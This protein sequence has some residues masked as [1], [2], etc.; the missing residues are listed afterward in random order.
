VLVDPQLARAERAR[1]LALDYT[2]TVP[3]QIERALA[4]HASSAHL[5]ALEAQLASLRVQVRE[6]EGDVH[7]LEAHVPATMEQPA[8][9]WLRKR[10]SSVVLPLSLI[11]NVILIAVALAESRVDE[12]NLVPTSAL[13]T[14]SQ[15][16]SPRPRHT[17]VPKS[18]KPKVDLHHAT[19]RA[20]KTP[21]TKRP[22]RGRALARPVTA[23]AIERKL[24][25]LVIQSPAGKLPPRLIDQKTGLAKNGL[26]ARCTPSGG[27]RS[28][29]CLVRPAHHRPT[30]GLYVGY[31]LGRSGRATLT[32]HRYRAG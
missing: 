23:G 10:V 19:T 25:A 11:V 29:L 5:R 15:A 32:W 22:Q 14:T 4:D 26:Q 18:R 13:T 28:F 30:E 1:L 6:L 2:E 12:P 9:G 21:S 3:P 24:L 7:T 31:R 27:S 16:S 17:S 8:S 20:R